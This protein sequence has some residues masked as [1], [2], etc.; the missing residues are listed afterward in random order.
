VTTHTAV[1]P[2]TPGGQMTGRTIAL[3]TVIMMSCL[4]NAVSAQDTPRVGISMGYPASIGVIWQVSDGLA[5]RPEISVQKSSTEFTE[6]ISFGLSTDGTLDTTTAASKSTSDFWQVSV[7]LSALVYLSKH[8]ALRTYV[9]PRWAYMRDSSNTASGLS[10]LRNFA[11]TASGHLVAG[12]FGAQ[13]ALGR[14]FNAFGE[15]GLAFTRTVITPNDRQSSSLIGGQDAS[16]TFGTRSA[17]GVIL[18]F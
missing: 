9:S 8:D 11:S 6:S 18:Y 12:S 14:K 7:G 15:V 3:V 17:A 16:S 5:L 1:L 10:N 13:Y 4:G 2:D